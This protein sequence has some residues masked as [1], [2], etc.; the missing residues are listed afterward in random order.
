M[1]TAVTTFVQGY[2]LP[3]F[4]ATSRVSSR[5]AVSAQVA[6]PA[7]S[8]L[9]DVWGTSPS[10][11]VQGMTLKTWDVSA[12]STDR[13]QVSLKSEG[14]PI[15]S[16]IE[17]WTTPSY[18]PTKMRVYTMDGKDRP[19]N[20]VIETPKET[21][22]VAV[23]NNAEIDFPFDAAVVDTGL[24]KAMEALSGE[25]P[26]LVQGAGAIR[27]YTFGPEV[28]S[29]QVLLKTAGL[30]ERNMKAMVEVTEGPNQV[31][32]IIEL[33]ASSGYKNP[34]YMTLALPATFSTVRIINE[35]TVEF[36]FDAYVVPYET[37]DGPKDA[38]VMGGM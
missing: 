15:E 37:N 8:P 32:Q 38:V 27:S 34:F 5:A 33:Y 2:Q 14:R 18:I 29:V 26:E 17:L 4:A 10:V 30:G 23:Y 36:P 19:V 22:T 20:A 28:D 13:V 6:A 31:K 35:N 9:T 12:P 3:Q 25:T 16:Q 24:G 11:R 21:N 1:L 7:A